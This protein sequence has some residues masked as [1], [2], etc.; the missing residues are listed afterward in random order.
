MI[1]M[2]IKEIKGDCKIPGYENWITLES[3]KFGT[4]R[5]IEKAN[6]GG[7]RDLE[8]GSEGRQEFSIDKSADIATVDLMYAAIRHR[9]TGEAAV[10][11]TVDIAFIEPRG[12]GSQDS[13]GTVKAYLKIRFGKA[14]IRSWDISGDAAKRASESVTFWYNQVAM[15]YDAPAADGKSYQ[16]YGPRGWDQQD[17]KDWVPSGWK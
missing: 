13:K 15:A 12:S 1:V 9:A 10:P 5:K 17:G 3:F 14:L 6:K 16:T 11:F 4:E 8:T 2:Q 7:G